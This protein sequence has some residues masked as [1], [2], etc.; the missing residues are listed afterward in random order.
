M[1]FLTF[2]G[3]PILNDPLYNHPV[4]G[5]E[6]GKGG[7]IGKTDDQL[8]ADLIAIHNAE[9]WLGG[10]VLDGA[11]GGGGPGGGDD[12]GMGG[13]GSMGVAIA[14]IRKVEEEQ[15]REMGKIITFDKMG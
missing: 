12:G 3:Y 2:A 8:I 15:K 7:R 11:D 1:H 10:G 6:K 13:G 4:F 5:P 14:A 9:N